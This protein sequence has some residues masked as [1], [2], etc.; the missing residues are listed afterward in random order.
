MGDVG[1]EPKGP[2]ENLGGGE[3]YECF[4]REDID[5]K[6]ILGSVL[7][8]NDRVRWEAEVELE[9]AKSQ[10]PKTFLC[11]LGTVF[12]DKSANPDTRRLAG[13][14]LKNSLTGCVGEFVNTACFQGLVENIFSVLQSDIQP[15]RRC[16]SQLSAELASYEIHSG[17]A[18]DTL[19]LLISSAASDQ[20]SPTLIEACLEAIGF[21]SEELI[22]KHGKTTPILLDQ[23]LPMLEV[24]VGRIRNPPTWEV[25]L[26]ASNTLFF[27]LDFLSGPLGNRERLAEIMEILFTLT[28][29]RNMEVRLSAFHCLVYLAGSIYTELFPFIERI[30]GKAERAILYDEEPPALQAL[31]FWS[32]LASVEIDN[33][34]NLASENGNYLLTHGKFES[35]IAPVAKRLCYVLLNCLMRQ[36]EYQDEDTW[37]KAAAARVCLGLLSRVAPSTVIEYVAP[38]ISENVMDENSWRRRE[39]ATMAL[40]I[41]AVDAMPAVLEDIVNESLP[42][43]LMGLLHDECLAVRETT[44]LTL[45]KICKVSKAACTSYFSELAQNLSSALRDD[46]AVAKHACRGLYNLADF[47]RFAD[48]VTESE[49]VS[50][51]QVFK[52]LMME[53]FSLAD[54]S[55]VEREGLKGLALRSIGNYVDC[56]PESCLPIL[57]EV[58]TALLERLLVLRKD[59]PLSPN[60]RA[61]IIYA[62]GILMVSLTR[63]LSRVNPGNTGLVFKAKDR[64]LEFIIHNTDDSLTEKALKL[65]AVIEK[66]LKPDANGISG[67]IAP[68]VLAIVNTGRDGSIAAG[69][70]CAAVDAILE[71]V[72]SAGNGFE[73]YLPITVQTI[74]ELL[75]HPEAV[76][77]FGPCLL[78]S[79]GELSHALGVGFQPH[80]DSSLVVMQEAAKISL[81]G[82]GVDQSLVSEEQVLQIRRSILHSTS[83]ILR[84]S[85]GNGQRTLAVQKLSWVLAICENVSEDDSARKL[86][87]YLADALVG[88]AITVVVEMMS[89]EAKGQVQ[90]WIKKLLEKG[91]SSTNPEIKSLAEKAAVEIGFHSA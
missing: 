81:S 50:L 57:S 39:A 4:V 45:S 19:S 27:L 34:E 55:S 89:V 56:A 69:T 67:Q 83:C 37:N 52:P 8:V 63:Y 17:L 47:Y 86:S 6:A 82:K 66:N 53:L 78:T 18:R 13:I 71:L 49:L 90:E 84:S 9:K 46:E 73:A 75:S 88:L 35:L 79:L 44:A 41:I 42:F 60:E 20:L 80:V 65:L 5:L 29:S 3:R 7:S 68:P 61:G 24:V 72:R 40:G 16:A 54:R 15:V 30:F 2:R 77:R 87:P 32:T 59:R 85:A 23:T 64:A 48:G 31:E 74:Q 33:L 10:N 28:D 11:D 70:M 38:F 51:A 76:W 43:L 62:Q 25:Q 26:K 22:S 21:I 1:V 14:V 91:I 36:E 58:A 12:A